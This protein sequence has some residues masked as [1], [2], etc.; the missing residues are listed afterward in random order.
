MTRTSRARMRSLMRVRGSGMRRGRKSRIGVSSGLP[1]QKLPRQ[2]SMRRY[3]ENLPPL[4]KFASNNGETT[5]EVYATFTVFGP[6]P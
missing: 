4:G 5:G 1:E 2:Y 6:V 3:V